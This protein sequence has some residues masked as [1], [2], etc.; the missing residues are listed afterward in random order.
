VITVGEVQAPPTEAAPLFGAAPTE[1]KTKRK[2]RTKAEMEAA[3]A[4]EAREAQGEAPVL[5]ATPEPAEE[6]VTGPWFDAA[7]LTEER[8]VTVARTPDQVTYAPGQS[9]DD[10]A[11]FFARV[12]GVAEA[13]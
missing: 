13:K 3:R 5:D 11:A 4:A 10:V 12:R 1:E 8:P 6:T 7:L 2:R 9:A